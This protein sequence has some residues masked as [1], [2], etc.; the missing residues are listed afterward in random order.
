MWLVTT[1]AGD[2]IAIYECVGEG[3]GGH[4]GECV[5]C[6]CVCACLVFECD[7]ATEEGDVWSGGR[8]DADAMWLLRVVCAFACEPPAASRGGALSSSCRW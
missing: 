6:M 7:I 8:G 2:A 4:V 5:F 3:T 1:A